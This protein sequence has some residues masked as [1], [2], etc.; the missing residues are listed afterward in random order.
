MYCRYY[1]CEFVRFGGDVV[2]FKH[3]PAQRKDKQRGKAAVHCA[4]FH[5]PFRVETRLFNVSRACAA[6]NNRY[7]C[8]AERYSGQHLIQSEVV[9]YRVCGYGCRSE[10]R[11]EREQDNFAEVEHK[12]FKTVRH[13]Y[14]KNVVEHFSFYYEAER[15][16]DVQ[17]SVLSEQVTQAYNGACHA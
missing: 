10:F 6:R 7:H 1:Q 16:R 8:E 5:Q 3:R 14:V 12:A 13:P 2:Y 11:D 15:Q 17:R 9:A 4:H